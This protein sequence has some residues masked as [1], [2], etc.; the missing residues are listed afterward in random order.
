MSSGSNFGAAKLRISE[1][2]SKF[3]NSECKE[4]LAYSLL[5]RDKIRFN[6]NKNAVFKFDLSSE[7]NFGVLGVFKYFIFFAENLSVVLDTFVTRADLP[8]LELVLPIDISFYTC[9]KESPYSDWERTDSGRNKARLCIVGN[10][11]YKK[12]SIP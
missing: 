3:W 1:N 9:H 5:S 10:W 4:K 2:K 12:T 8:T 11:R 6:P 7:S